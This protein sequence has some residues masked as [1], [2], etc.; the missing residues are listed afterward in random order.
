ME[1]DP[2]RQPPSLNPATP[3]IYPGQKTHDMDPFVSLA[4]KVV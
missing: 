2:E 1:I 3:V 4:A